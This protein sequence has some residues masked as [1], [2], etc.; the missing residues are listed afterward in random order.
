MAEPIFVTRSMMP[1]KEEYFAEVSDIWDSCWLT[2][3][4]THHRKLETQLQKYLDIDS[5]ALLS[6]GHMSLEAAI[7]A[8]DLKGEVIT[9]P[10]TFVSTIHALVRN[11]IKPVF[12]DIRRDDYTLDVEKAE[13]LITP[14]TVAIMPVHV[15]GNVCDIEGFDRLA[16]K[17]NI[18]IIYDAAHTFGETYKGKSVV[19]YGD[20]AT[21]SFH[22]TKVF[23]TI[24]GGAVCSADSSI[25]ERINK[26]KNFGIVDEEM[27]CEVGFNA[28]M[29]EF[30]AAMGTCNLRHIEEE[31]QGRKRIYQE[32]ID[33]LQDCKEISCNY[34]K[35]D[36]APNYAYFPILVEG[37][38]ENRDKVLEALKKQN[39][40]ARKYFYPLISN[41]LCY[42]GM[43][44]NELLPV[45]EEVSRKVL[46]LPIY[47][48]LKL[49]DVH[50]ICS[51]IQQIL[52]K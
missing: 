23:H 13:K 32:Y 35:K 16:E 15:Y 31:I 43:Y 29:N 18:K 22:A 1:T 26:M 39:I 3:M 47:S 19:S 34:Y 24:E 45:A 51:V 37:D 11:G 9:T 44:G 36:V 50:K 40:Y 4:G 52:K 48:S 6:S 42:K 41:L 7:Q 14:E 17:Y 33:C 25:V 10:F 49:E 21:L 20:A 5:I 46:T 30:Q 28:K 27:I 2:N 38:L 8:F 12:C